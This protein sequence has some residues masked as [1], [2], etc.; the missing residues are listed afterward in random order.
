MEFVTVKT[1]KIVKVKTRLVLN[2]ASFLSVFF[3]IKSVITFRYK[4]LY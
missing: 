1:K 3:I 2:R 4:F